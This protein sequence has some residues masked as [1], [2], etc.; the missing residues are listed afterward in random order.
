MDFKEALGE[1]F[2]KS[3]KNEGQPGGATVKFARS[4][5][6]AQGSLVQI[7]SVDMTLLGRPCCGRH[8]I[9]KVDE[10]EHGC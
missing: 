10:D 5:S 8:P 6:A 3:K 4:A 7:P 9:Y 2:L 1:D